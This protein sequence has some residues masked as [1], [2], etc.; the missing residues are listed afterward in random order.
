MLIDALFRCYTKKDLVVKDNSGSY[1]IHYA[2]F[3][4]LGSAKGLVNKLTEKNMMAFF[5]R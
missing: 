3:Y 1:H 4:D 2:S 5:I